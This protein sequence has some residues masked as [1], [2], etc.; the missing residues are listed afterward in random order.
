MGAKPVGGTRM[1][2][3]GSR[4]RH[5]LCNAVGVLG[6]ALVALG[7]KLVQFLVAGLVTI[8]IS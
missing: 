3:S 5:S 8:V 4:N 1:S 6:A 7:A 2:D